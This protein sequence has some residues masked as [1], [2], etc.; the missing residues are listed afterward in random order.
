MVPDTQSLKFFNF[1]N[2]FSLYVVPSKGSPWYLLWPT[3]FLSAVNLS[4]KSFALPPKPTA[5]F[6]KRSVALSRG[7][8]CLAFIC[9]PFWN[10]LPNPLPYQRTES[11]GLCLAC[12]SVPCAFVFAASQCCLASFAGFQRF[13][14]IFV[15][16]IKSVF[17]HPVSLSSGHTAAASSLRS[18]WRSSGVCS[19]CQEVTPVLPFIVVWVVYSICLF[20]TNW[21]DLQGPSCSLV[22]QLGLTMSVTCD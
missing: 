12:C 7:Y 10:Q 4:A 9:L 14:S 15:F 5:R 20:A 17:S 8:S 19:R 11:L 1:Y 2:K 18:P 3:E 16:G 22:C 21:G 13:P 6:E